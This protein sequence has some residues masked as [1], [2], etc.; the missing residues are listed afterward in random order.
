MMTQTPP[1]YVFVLGNEKGGAGKTT[2]SM[3]L[4]ASLLSLGFKVASLDVDSRQHSL[5]RY[6]ENRAQTTER[7]NL[8][9]GMPQHYLVPNSTADAISAQEAEELEL[10]TA[11]MD[12]ARAH[13]DFI[14]IDT[15]GNNSHL[16]RLAHSF[17]DTII[18]PM[19]DSF[20]DLDLLAKVDPDKLSILEPS[21]YS[22]MIWEQKLAR[23]RRDRGSIQWMVMRNR[24]GH[25][26]QKNKALMEQTLNALAERIRFTH[27]PGFS[28]RVVFRELF[29]Q[30]LTLLDLHALSKSASLNLSHVA[31]RQ[32]LRQFLQHL[33]HPRINEALA[34]YPELRAKVSA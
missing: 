10:F 14:V 28:E 9:L 15:P 12:A 4:I 7:H 25:V 17:A 23:A 20:I 16:S 24:L 11:A 18:T 21:I 33:N 19:N 31:A 6:I 27:A 29:P 8:A 3:H 34:A 22:Q 26:G 2:C 5:T 30:G 1:P 13:A 32:E